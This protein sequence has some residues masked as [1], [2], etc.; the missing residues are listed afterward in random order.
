MLWVWVCARKV[1][2]CWTLVAVAWGDRS[3]IVHLNVWLDGQRHRAFPSFLFTSEPIMWH[4]FFLILIVFSVCIFRSL[5]HSLT[6]YFSFP[7]CVSQFLCLCV[8][9]PTCICTIFICLYFPPHLE[10]RGLC[11][12]LSIF[13]YNNFMVTWVLCFV[14]PSFNCTLLCQCGHICLYICAIWADYTFVAIYVLN[15]IIVWIVCL[16]NINYSGC[17]IPVVKTGKMKSQFSRSWMW[18]SCGLGPC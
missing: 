12:F 8:Y 18:E 2:E 5:F 15:S 13:M 6:V 16:Y 10:S 3:Q 14:S 17:R 4:A 9:T 1:T 7:V 11:F